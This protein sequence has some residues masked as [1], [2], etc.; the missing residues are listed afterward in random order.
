MQITSSKTPQDVY[1]HGSL[2]IASGSK[3]QI[4]NKS[5]RPLMIFAGDAEPA[6]LDDYFIVEAWGWHEY[7]GTVIMI[8]SEF[9]SA[10][11]VQVID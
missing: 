2:S 1:A 11:M 3:V 6:S 9:D 10:V 5:P 7:Q 8:W 4:Q